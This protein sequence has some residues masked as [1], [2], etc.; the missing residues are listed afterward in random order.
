MEIRLR[1]HSPFYNFTLSQLL[2]DFIL[3]ILNQNLL[4]YQST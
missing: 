4:F 2:L 3:Y 1:S